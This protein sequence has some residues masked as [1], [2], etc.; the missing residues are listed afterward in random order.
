MATVATDDLNLQH[1]KDDLILVFTAVAD[2]HGDNAS[3]IR[4]WVKS[5]GKT[6]A[7]RYTRELIGVLTTHEWLAEDDNA[8]VPRLDRVADANDGTLST[9]QLFERWLDEKLAPVA[10]PKSSGKTRITSTTPQTP[11]SAT[12]QSNPADLPVCRCGCGEVLN[13]RKS[14][15]RPGHDARHASAVAKEAAASHPSEEWEKLFD[16][17]GLVSPALRLKARNMA[18]RI[19]AKTSAKADAK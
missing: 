17:S 10:R 9:V 7:L 5:E 13:N 6:L 18:D 16:S 15:Y 2:G 12:K 1:M 11:R 4:A 19:C 14:A 3:D 8:L